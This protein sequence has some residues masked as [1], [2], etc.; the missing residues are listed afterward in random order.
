MACVCVWTSLQM[1]LIGK[2]TGIKIGESPMLR[3]A[4]RMVP[5]ARYES[6]NYSCAC[7]LRPAP[8]QSE[9]DKAEVGQQ[10]NLEPAAGDHHVYARGNPPACKAMACV[11]AWTSLHMYLIGNFTPQADKS[12]LTARLKRTHGACSPRW[13]E[14]LFINPRRISFVPFFAMKCGGSD[15]DPVLRI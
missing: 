7:F 4:E 1:Y 5:C 11:C 12:F 13:I 9:G 8:F 15:S 14:F 6:S 10:Q 2:S 3:R